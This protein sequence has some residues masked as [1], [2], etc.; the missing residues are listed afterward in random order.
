[1]AGH[2]SHFY[3]P[4]REVRALAPGLNP[5]QLRG[6]MVFTDAKT[7]DARLVWRVLME[8]RRDGAVALNY[9]AAKSLD[10]KDGRVRGVMLE[11]AL[12]GQA[13]FART[14]VVMNATGAWADVLRQCMGAKPVLRPLRGSHLVVPYWRLP[15]AQSLSLMHPRVGGPVFL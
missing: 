15:V 13:F 8:A 11:D 14:P 9:V 10:M 1:M 5:P 6:A 3:A 4:L 12:T 2:K 7:D